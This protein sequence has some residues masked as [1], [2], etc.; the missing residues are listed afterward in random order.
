[1]QKYL[2]TFLTILLAV[3]AYAGGKVTIQSEHEHERYTMIIEYQ[4][5]NTLR[6]TMPGQGKDSGYMLIKEGKMYTV[7]NI[8]NV[9]MVMDMGAMTRMASAFG[10]TGNEQNTGNGPLGYQVLETKDTGKKE[11]VAGFKGEIYQITTS[12]NGVTTTREVVLSSAPAVRDYSE[13]WYRAAQTMQRV[14]GTNIASDNDLSHYMLAHKLGLLR[15]GKEFII[16]SID[17][18][19]PSQTRFALPVQ[20]VSMPDLGSMFGK[21]AQ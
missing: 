2:F 14:M 13:A 1:M 16:T 9:P 18:A 20:P 15:Y 11:T 21:P 5:N 4:D 17:P 3:N 8:N 19:T 6:M 10:P 7:T 12:S